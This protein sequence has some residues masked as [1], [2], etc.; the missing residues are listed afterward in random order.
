M[1]LSN[2]TS[3]RRAVI[4]VCRAVISNG[5]TIVES[6]LTDDRG[7]R[8]RQTLALSSVSFHRL[9]HSKSLI[10]IKDVCGNSDNKK[11]TR[12]ELFWYLAE[13]YRD[14]P[15]DPP[16]LLAPSGLPAVFLFIKSENAAEG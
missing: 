13:H 1:L 8:M 9:R 3:S 15:A 14:V 4:I 6:P 11:P 2:F 12:M 10:F 7:K 16:S 5:S